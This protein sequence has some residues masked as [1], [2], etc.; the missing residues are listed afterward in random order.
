MFEGLKRDGRKGLI[1][2]ITAGDPSPDRTPALVEALDVAD[3]IHAAGVAVPAVEDHG[4]VDID[5]VAVAQRLIGGHAVT[6]DMVDRG[7][8]GVA[9]TAITQARRQRAVADGVIVGELVE[10]GRGHARFHFRH[11]QVEH[12]GRQPSGPPHALEVLFRVQ[13]H[14]EMSAARGF[15]RFGF[16][17]QSK[18]GALC[19]D[20]ECKVR[21]RALPARPLLIPPTAAHASAAMRLVNCPVYA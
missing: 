1:A 7:A 15:E 20:A 16:G 19:L 11:Q 18:H 2:Y 10:M 9:V 14:R 3:Q 21:C 17:H 6:D 12:L 4:H 13:G 5:D 8:Q